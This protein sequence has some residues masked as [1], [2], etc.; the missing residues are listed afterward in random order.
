M[1]QMRG[2]KA[3]SGGPLCRGGVTSWANPLCLGDKADVDQSRGKTDKCD[4]LL[5]RQQEGKKQS[6]GVRGYLL[7]LRSATAQK[8]TPLSIYGDVTVA[9]VVS[10]V[11]CLK[12]STRVS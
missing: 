3:E 9:V 7:L 11:I 1:L 5:R 4:N 12:I 10:L 8:T 6:R 2:D